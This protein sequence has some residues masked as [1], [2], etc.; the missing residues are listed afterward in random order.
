MIIMIIFDSPSLLRRAQSRWR[1]RSPPEDGF[2][3]KH[4]NYDDGYYYYFDNILP[5]DD[6]LTPA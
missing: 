2:E 6:V 5:W 4:D 3:L 1:G